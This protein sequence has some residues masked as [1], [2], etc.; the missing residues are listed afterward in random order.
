MIT[1]GTNE[2]P[3]VFVIASVMK[4]TVSKAGG[5]TEESTQDMHKDDYELVGELAYIGGCRKTPI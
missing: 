4:Q 1:A 5:L 2:A 3:G